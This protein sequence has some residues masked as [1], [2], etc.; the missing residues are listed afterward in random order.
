MDRQDLFN[1]LEFQD[2]YIVDQKVQPKGFFEDVPS[3]FDRHEQFTP[4]RN[5]PHIPAG[6]ICCKCSRLAPGL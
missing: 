1:D 5:R 6:N 2:Q 3:L 4:Y